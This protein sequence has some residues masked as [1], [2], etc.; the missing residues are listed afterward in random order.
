MSY[1]YPPFIY[2]MISLIKVKAMPIEKYTVLPDDD[3]LR[4]VKLPPPNRDQNDLM[5]IMPDGSMRLSRIAFRPDPKRDIDGLSVNIVALAPSLE[6][7]FDSNTHLGVVFKAS[8]YF[9]LNLSIT[10]DPLT[11]KVEHVDY[12]HA[13]VLQLMKQEGLQASLAESYF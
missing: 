9:D 7:L 10:H 8:V 2:W 1:Q 11:E 12:S 4:R 6:E 13:L 3:I 5:K